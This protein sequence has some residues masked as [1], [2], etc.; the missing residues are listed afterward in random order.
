MDFGKISKFV[1]FSEHKSV[2]CLHGN[3]PSADFFD[4]TELSIIAAD[5][6]A[7]NLQK[8]GVTPDLI[9]GDLDSVKEEL[10]Y[11]NH[12]KMAD[13]N[14]SDFQKALG[15][16]ESNDLTPTIVCG[17]NGGYIDHILNNINIFCSSK[18]TII[19]RSTIGMCLDNT[20]I[21]NFPVN[22]KLSIFG[23]PNCIIST[24]G[25]KWEL[26]ETVLVFPGNCSC[27]NRTMT[28][29]IVVDVKSGRVLLIV[30]TDRIDDA[31]AGW[32]P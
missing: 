26:D 5:G 6:G 24:R 22:T 17:I 12:L 20:R 8:I 15:Y 3:L 19:D 13:Q 11:I 4:S 28:D 31:G 16:V 27:F 23:M 2:I 32:I 1:D 9:I 25:L 30:Y 10:L 29:D 21:F 7:N 18:A 14:Y